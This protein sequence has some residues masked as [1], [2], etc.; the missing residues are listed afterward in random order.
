[1]Q[2]EYLVR[3]P[4]ACGRSGTGWQVVPVLLMAQATRMVRAAPA[5][6]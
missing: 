3:Q 5:V 1:M 6:R 2:P 4:G